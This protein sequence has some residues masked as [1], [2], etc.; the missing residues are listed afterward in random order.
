[1]IEISRSDDAHDYLGTAK[2]MFDA[3]MRCGYGDPELMIN[4]SV[5][6][7]AAGIAQAEALTR[8]AELESP[9]AEAGPGDTS[10]EETAGPTYWDAEN[11]RIGAAVRTHYGKILAS[12]NRMGQVPDGYAREYYEAAAADVARAVYPKATGQ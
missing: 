10:T 4:L 7:V 2:T 11:A 3:A 9:R 8:L 12:L 5:G 1:M 6:A